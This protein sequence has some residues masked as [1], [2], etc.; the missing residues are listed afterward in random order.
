M[1]DILESIQFKKYRSSAKTHQFLHLCFPTAFMVHEEYL[2]GIQIDKI[3]EKGQ[4][5]QLI[6]S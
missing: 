4:N 5:M 3:I 1:G 6:A 2:E